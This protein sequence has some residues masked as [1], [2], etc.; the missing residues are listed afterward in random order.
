MKVNWF[1]LV[2]MFITVGAAVGGTFIKNE[3]SKKTFSSVIG[4]VS[5]VAEGLANQNP[6]GT[7]AQQAFTGTDTKVGVP[8]SAH[9]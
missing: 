5:T 6:D 3:D 4:L 2:Q 1:K 7:P 9:V 8:E